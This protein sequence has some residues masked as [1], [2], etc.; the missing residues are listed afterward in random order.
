MARPPSPLITLWTARHRLLHTPLLSRATPLPAWMQPTLMVSDWATRFIRSW[1]TT[2]N[3]TCTHSHPNRWC[4]LSLRTKRIEG[5]W[6]IDSRS[7]WAQ[8]QTL[9]VD[10]SS[11]RHSRCNRIA[12]AQACWRGRRPVILAGDCRLELQ[13]QQ[14]SKKKILLKHLVQKD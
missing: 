6:S 13:L 11:C 1:T 3:Q 14:Y 4:T 5:T 2:R 12:Q 10:S 7:R 9:Q 8:F